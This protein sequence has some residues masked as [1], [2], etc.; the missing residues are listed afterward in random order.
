MIKYKNRIYRIIIQSELDM[1]TYVYNFD[2]SDEYTFYLAD[3]EYVAVKK[4]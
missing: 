4:F 3:M 1:R 2:E